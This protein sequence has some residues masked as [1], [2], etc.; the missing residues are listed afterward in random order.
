MKLLFLGT[1][2][3]LE[4]YI[5]AA[6]DQDLEVA[7][8]IDSD[9]YGNRDTFSG[10]PVVDSQKV[11]DTE[12]DKYR[13]YVFFIGTNWSPLAGRDTTKRKM[14]IDIVKR[15]SLP[16][17]NLIHRTSFISKF[18]EL[19]QNIFI[20]SQVAIEP[21]CKISS[22][23]TIMD[24]VSIAHDSMIGE[25]CVIQRKAGVQ[26]TVGNN[27][28]IAGDTTIFKHG[29]LNIGNDVCIDPCLYVSRNVKDGERVRLTKNNIRVYRSLNEV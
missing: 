1:N 20:G 5:E 28:Y 22:F 23:C 27:T 14:L 10:I 16:C 29:G 15:Y 3:V 11:F 26:A 17:V 12:P 19:G 8:I 25:N 24:L 6:E 2:S 7:G 13:D 4:R 18:S 21:N 9:W